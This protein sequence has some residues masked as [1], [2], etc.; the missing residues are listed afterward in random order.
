MPIDI[1]KLD[2]PQQL[3]M[4]PARKEMRYGG[5]DSPDYEV[6]VP[7][8]LI[9][10]GLETQGYSDDS[11]SVVTGY[12]SSKPV[13]VNGV[14][15]FATYDTS[16]RLLGYEGD[17]ETT[18]WINKKQRL[19]GNWD[20]DGRPKPITATSRGAG[21]RGVVNDIMSDPI[22][23]AAANIAAS[24]FGGP[25]GTA[26]LGAVQ[27]KSLEDIAKNAAISYVAGQV[28]E[29]VSAG[30]S[31]EL[32]DL[33][34]SGDLTAA[35]AASLAKVA[36]N[37]ASTAVR[38]GDPLQALI[39]GGIGV[40]TAALTAEIPGFADMN[41]YQQQAVN[42]AILNTLQGK[43]PSQGLINEA[44]ASGISA[45]TN[46]SD[47]PSSELINQTTSETTPVSSN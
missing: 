40:G 7:P 30:V 36:G 2:L 9:T 19:I 41:K 13:N 27:G 21:I 20:A 29:G 17:Y 47:A 38:G 16:G 28:A 10:E 14:P 1:Q 11:G 24:Y 12:R 37:V 5:W 4:T 23:G 42:K 34:K 15:V 46:Y 6:D 35:Q 39:T 43:D 22:L 31:T 18:P 33:V 25:L 45:A 32:A 26:A 3:K 8:Q 44:I